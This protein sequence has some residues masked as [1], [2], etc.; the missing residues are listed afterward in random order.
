MII[1]D[2]DRQPRYLDG[3]LKLRPATARPRG[4]GRRYGSV[5]RG[6]GRGHQGSLPR[7]GGRPVSV[8]ARSIDRHTARWQSRT[9][10]SDA[11]RRQNHPTTPGSSRCSRYGT[12]KAL[13]R[14]SLRRGFPEGGNRPKE[15]ILANVAVTDGSWRNIQRRCYQIR[16]CC[17]FNLPI[18]VKLRMM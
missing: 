11:W 17:C 7:G 8:G 6:N 12:C 15:R 9:C 5:Q 18:L 1:D 10:G 3:W 16:K 4:K 2:D 13:L 14:G